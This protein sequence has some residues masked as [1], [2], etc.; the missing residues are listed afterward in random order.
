MK[1]LLLPLLLFST[2]MASEETLVEVRLMG[3]DGTLLP[4]AK[5]PRIV[6]SDEEWRQILSPEAYAITRH[7]HT[8]RPFCGVFVDN[9]KTGYYSCICCG[10][11]LFRSADK[12]ESGT[13]WPSF[14]QPIAKE[15]LGERVDTSHG[16][17]RTE[18]HCKRCGAHQGHVFPDGPPP[19]RL[20]YCINSAALQFHETKK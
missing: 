5:M 17:V 10:L 16:M 9:H 7:H 15:N 19:T 4:P 18:I 2:A 20:R 11:P 8:E 6:K 13:G 1:R 3:E 12:F 14:F